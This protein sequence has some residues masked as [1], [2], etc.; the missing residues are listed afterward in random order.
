LSSISL[1]DRKQKVFFLAGSVG[2]DLL[3]NIESE[4]REVASERRL[5]PDPETLEQMASAKV[6]TAAESAGEE[7]DT[8]RRANGLSVRRLGWSVLLRSVETLA[9]DLQAADWED[10]RKLFYEFAC[11][12]ILRPDRLFDHVDYLPR[13]LSLAVALQDWSEARKLW[14]TCQHSIEKLRTAP[15][16]RGDL[17]SE[18]SI[19]GYPVVSAKTTIWDG[20]RDHLRQVIYN[21]KGFH[22]GVVVCSELQ[23][24]S[25]RSG[26]QGSVDCMMVLSWNQDLETFSALVESAAL[27]VHAYVAYVNNR[28]FGD[29]RVRVPAKEAFNRDA[30]RLRGGHNDYLVVVDID[31]GSLRAFQSRHKRWAGS[32]DP[33]KPVPEGFRLLPSRKMTPR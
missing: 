1:Q 3:E 27:D 30:C 26:F 7:V 18:C 12:H 11:A 22:F 29:S 4:I 19:N 8:L 5:L 23:N 9:R 28:A 6:L 14:R 31:I 21:H 2:K 17:P 24:I 10:Q 13:L 16:L 33:Y 15:E 20:L 32:G 25:Y